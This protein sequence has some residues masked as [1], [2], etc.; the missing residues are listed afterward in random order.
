VYRITRED[1]TYAMEHGCAVVEAEVAAGKPRAVGTRSEGYGYPIRVM[2]VL[3]SG[4]SVIPQS[5]TH[6]YSK[7]PVLRPGRYVIILQ[8]G[9]YYRAERL[10][11]GS[12][13]PAE[14]RQWTQHN[15]T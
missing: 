14:I 4:E 9:P 12:A 5:F 7:V 10:S 15:D 3:R 8:G 1:I 11:R 13:R 6:D 2:S